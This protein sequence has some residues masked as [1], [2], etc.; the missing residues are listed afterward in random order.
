MYQ[1]EGRACRVNNWPDTRV[2]VKNCISG[3]VCLIFIIPDTHRVI[4]LRLSTSG[5]ITIWLSHL[6]SHASIKILTTKVLSPPGY[7]KIRALTG[8]N[9]KRVSIELR[10]AA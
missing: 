2:D 8:I 5:V 3:E 6:L 4:N 7:S 1:A 9:R 10:T